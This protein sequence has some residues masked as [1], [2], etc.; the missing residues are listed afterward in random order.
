MSAKDIEADF[1]TTTRN[2]VVGFESLTINAA[3]VGRQML[4][5]LNN[6]NAG[7]DQV[8]NNV[9]YAP[10]QIAALIREQDAHAVLWN[11]QKKRYCIAS[12]VHREAAETHLKNL[13]KPCD[14]AGMQTHS[15]PTARVEKEGQ[16][17]LVLPLSPQRLPKQSSDHGHNKFPQEFSRTPRELCLSSR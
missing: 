6:S 7:M 11:L 16:S 1:K 3:D 12:K 14:T 8:V 2:N 10:K 5:E 17:L 13:K 4:R 15:L 9:R